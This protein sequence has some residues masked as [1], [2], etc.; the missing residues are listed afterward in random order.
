VQDTE[1]FRIALH[2]YKVRCRHVDLI[3][4][5]HARQHK[6]NAI[7]WTS[8]TPLGGE[9]LAAPEVDFYIDDDMLHIADIKVA[10]CFGEYFVSQI[11]KML[12]SSS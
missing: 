9:R 12:S 10:R 1:T 5:S 11:N 8:G 4:P 7:V 3:H 2:N 6:T